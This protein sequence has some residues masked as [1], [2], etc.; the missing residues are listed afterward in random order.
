L[1]E[2]RRVDNHDQTGSSLDLILSQLNPTIFTT[3]FS[4][5]KVNSP[6]GLTK[7]DAMK[8]YPSLNCALHPEN[9]YGSGGIAPR[10]L[11]LGIGGSEWSASRPSHVTPGERA[12]TH[13]I[14]SWMGPRAGL[15]TVG[16][17]KLISSP[18]P[19][20]FQSVA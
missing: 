7:C 11:N 8:T 1:L 10:I 15:D 19:G 5:R 17:I 12:A 3:L 20:F 6:L 13:W 9:L 16:K 2:N 14:G 18:L 4:Y